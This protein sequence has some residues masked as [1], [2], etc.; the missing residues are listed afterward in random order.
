MG[1]TLACRA[2]LGP[3]PVRAGILYCL[4]SHRLPHWAQQSNW[5]SPFPSNPNPNARHRATQAVA[6]L[7]HCHMQRGPSKLSHRC[8]ACV[9]GRTG[10]GPVSHAA[11]GRR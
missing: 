6:L 8:A 5:G 1:V 2:W 9:H 11:S 4:Y 10:H 3:P 7:N